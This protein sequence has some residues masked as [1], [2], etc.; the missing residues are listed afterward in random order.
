MQHIRTIQQVP[1]QTWLILLERGVLTGVIG[2]GVKR[3]A[4][5]LFEGGWAFTDHPRA[6]RTTGI[7]LGSGAVWDGKA[8]SLIAPSHSADAVYVLRRADRIYASNSL[9]FVVTGAGM[10]D[11][12]ITEMREPIGSLMKGL[13]RYSREIYSASGVHLYRY[14]NA[15]V[16]CRQGAEPV[17]VPQEADLSEIRSFET[18]RQYL[19]SAIAQ[20]ST[21]YGSTGTTV[22][23]S[24]GYDSAACAALA[25]Q[26]ERECIAISIDQARSRRPDDGSEIARALG[27]RIVTLKRPERRTMVEKGDRVWDYVTQADIERLSDFYFGTNVADE[28]LSAP[29]ELLAGRTVLTGFH[30]DKIWDPLVTPSPDLVRGDSSGAYMGEFR[31]RVGFLHIPVPML[32]FGAHVALR[33]IGLSRE[34]R[35]WWKVRSMGLGFLPIPVPALAVK[36]HPI[37]MTMG[38]FSD[39]VLKWRTLGTYDRPIPRRIAEEAGVPRQAFGQRKMAA[40]TFVKDLD[41]IA[42]QL[43]QRLVSRYEVAT[44]LIHLSVNAVSDVDEASPAR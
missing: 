40:A 5:W 18:Y 24:S 34:M 8:L 14:F 44:R 4:D 21:S 2:I 35:P 1:P 3:G 42:P 6:L 43:F 31:L 22:Y 12:P 13:R 16:E 26:G 38:R 30:G 20:A 39:R 37:V 41:A 17:E 32:A 9:P 27:M 15:I 25:K 23:L 36:T 7:Y 19:I 33:A 28:S 11:L 10:A 29:S